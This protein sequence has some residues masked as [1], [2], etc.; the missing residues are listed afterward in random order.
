LVCKL[1]R[2]ERGGR[3]TSG[4]L[5]VGAHERFRIGSPA[6]RA[7][8]TELLIQGA[9]VVV[10]IEIRQFAG[11][12]MLP[13]DCLDAAVGTPLEVPRRKIAIDPV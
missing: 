8:T 4:K 5:P 3:G 9:A 6:Y 10:K 11:D 12:A 2:C 13:V 1:G 7:A